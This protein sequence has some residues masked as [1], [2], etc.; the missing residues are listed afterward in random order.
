MQNYLYPAAECGLLPAKGITVTLGDVTATLPGYGESPA[1]NLLVPAVDPHHQW[2]NRLARLL[3]YAL[4]EA[5]DAAPGSARYGVHI[6]G[7][8]GTGKTSSVAQLCAAL[9]T[10]LASI[11]A[12]EDLDIKTLITSVE[13]EAGTLIKRNGPLRQAM[14]GGYPFVINE[15]D[16]ARP[17]LLTKLFGILDNGMYLTDDGEK[18]V[19]KRGFLLVFTSNAGGDGD[20]TGNTAGARRQSEALKRRV[21]GFWLDYASNAEEED[22][23]AKRLGHQPK[24]VRPFVKVAE[25]TRQ[26]YKAGIN[27]AVGN[28]VPLNAALTRQH[29][30]SWINQGFAYLIGEVKAKD[31]KSIK[32]TEPW[33]EAL[34]ETYGHTLL[35]EQWSAVSTTAEALIAQFADQM[36]QQVVAAAQKAQAKAA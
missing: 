33:V 6:K 18:I 7:P 2:N 1:T 34:E 5:W 32:P 17:G 8:P 12:D 25:A 9:G 23:L 31:P 4:K 29:L 30:V 21:K 36:L 26:Q 11:E 24:T 35:P 13:V 27:G 20:L 3:T 19:A 16:N 22:F 14:E 10:P 28:A 15:W